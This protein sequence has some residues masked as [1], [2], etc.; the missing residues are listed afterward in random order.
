MP[1]TA[2]VTDI[3][4]KVRN[5][6]ADAERDGIYL[7]VSGDRLE[8]DWLYVAISPA[9]PGVRA[10]DHARLMAHIERQLRQQGETNVLLVPALDE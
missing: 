7:Q 6:L 5:L 10:S 2:Q 4:E 9:R 8:D 3:V 1:T